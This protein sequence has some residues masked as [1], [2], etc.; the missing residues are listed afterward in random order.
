MPPTDLAE[1][2]RFLPTIPI[3][4]GIQGPTLDRIIEMLQVQDV[5]PGT[6]VCREGEPGRSMYVVQTGEVVVTRQSVPGINVKMMRMGPGEFFGELT[7][8]DPQPRATTVT[9]VEPS[10]LLMLTGRD[11]VT[12]YREDVQG[13]VMVLQNLCREFSRR[14]R[15]ADQRICEIAGADDEAAEVTQISTRPR[16]RG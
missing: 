1:L 7:L 2:R 16:L 5:E 12:L 6:R 11:L 4:G 8:I 9:V 14:L 15:R 10:R 3:F 13:Y